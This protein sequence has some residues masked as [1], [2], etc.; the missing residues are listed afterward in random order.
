VASGFSRYGSNQKFACKQSDSNP[1]NLESP[2]GHVNLFVMLP[3][4]QYFSWAFS[5][6]E[7]TRFPVTLPACKR[8]GATPKPDN[9]RKT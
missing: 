5:F 1:I 4:V 2:I 6:D 7:G 8:F 9:G 3:F